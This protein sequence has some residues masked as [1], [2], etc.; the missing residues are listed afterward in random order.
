M[1]ADICS[2][3]E[4]WSTFSE[5]TNPDKLEHSSP[6]CSFAKKKRAQRACHN[7]CARQNV[8]NRYVL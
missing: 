2:G 6:E 7:L 4:L 3:I 5:F 8:Y 1:Q